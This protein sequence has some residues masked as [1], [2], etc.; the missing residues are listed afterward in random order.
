MNVSFFPSVAAGTVEVPP[1]KSIAH[2]ALIAAAFAEGQSIVEN[3]ILSEDILATVDC[4]RALGAEIILERNTAIVNGVDPHR[5]PDRAV[6]PCRESGS[7]LRFLIP[8]A[9]TTDKQFSFTGS[10]RLFSRPLGIYEDICRNQGLLFLRGDDCLSVRGILI[11]GKYQIPG[12]VSSQFVSG[13]FF[14]LPFLEGDSE[15]EILPPVESVPYLNLSLQMLARCGIHI[16]REKNCF[17]IRGGQHFSPLCFRVEGDWTN[18]AYLSALGLKTDSVHVT[19]LD[20]GS[21]QGDRIYPQFFNE[22]LEDAPVLDLSDH[23]DLGPVL[24]VLAATLHGC[25]FTGI[26]RLRLKESDRIASMAEELRKFGARL[27]AEADTVTILPAPL[28][29]PDSVISGHGDHRVVMALSVLTSAFGGTIQGFEAVKKSFPGYY[30][31][32]RQLGI[33]CSVIDET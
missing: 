31:V 26:K 1:S 18:A 17:L 3:L 23:P 9:L 25:V 10:P 27:I 15:I 2:R 6:L 11:P 12:D 7:T 32:L 4:L 29:T 14:A 22:L 28:H 5:I 19:G 13:L 33:Q 24:F 16:I 8:F 21:V 30:D 20:D